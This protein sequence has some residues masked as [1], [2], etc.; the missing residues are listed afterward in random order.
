MSGLHL[1][2]ISHAFG[3]NKVLNG[4]SVFVAPGEL[5]CLL[6]PSG[7]G[8]T[9]LLRLAAGL[10]ALQ[11]GQVEIDGRVVGDGVKGHHLPP[12][13]RDVG[14]MF[15]DYALFPHLTVRENIMF[16]IEKKHRTERKDA[17][18]AGM[19]SMGISGYA[20]AYPHTLSGGQQQRVALL[21]ALAPDPKVLLLDEPFS[22]LDVTRRAQVRT[23]TLRIIKD[24]GV[25]TLMVTHDP[26][27]AMFMADRILVMNEGRIVQDG[28]PTDLYFK[29]QTPFVTELFGTVNKFISVAR[30]GAVETPVGT[31]PV[32]EQ[33]N[34]I[35][36]H[37]LIR[38][39]AF[40]VETSGG[41]VNVKVVSAR[42]L[43]RSSVVMMTLE[44]GFPIEARFPGMFLPEPGTTV[45]L[46]VKRDQLHI[47]PEG[48][49]R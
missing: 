10:E 3:P 31:F 25:G 41:D 28:T 11:T 22:G 43:G 29:P 38:P 47:F 12:E 23:E 17:I 49:T 26:E 16:G 14:L 7:C 45:A 42:P 32:N 27:E 18:S 44:S 48:G 36:L 30:N 2:A 20:D 5:V 39:E 33:L 37:I 19:V 8:K 15:Q 1:R 13:K 40:Q 24:A 34:D 21:R 6:G 9:T 46:T 4:V 35:E